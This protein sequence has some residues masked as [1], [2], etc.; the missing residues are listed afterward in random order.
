MVVA[1]G[2]KSEAS[3]TVAS[4]HVTE[5]SASFENISLSSETLRD[6]GTSLQVSGKYRSWATS[7]VPDVD[8]DDRNSPCGGGKRR[9]SLVVF[10]LSNFCAGTFYSLMGPFFPNEV[11]Q[12]VIDLCY[13]VMVWSDLLFY[14]VGAYLHV[15]LLS[16]SL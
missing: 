8:D 9:L 11:C 5:I 10:C 1:S 3:P 4:S 7:Y 16:S 13:Y 6:L 14:V 2:K 15:G 12:Y